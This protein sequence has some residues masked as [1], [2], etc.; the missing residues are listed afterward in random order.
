MRTFFN[1]LYHRFAWT[2]DFV[3]NTV[4]IGMWNNWIYSVLPEVK[5]PMVLELGH[6][7]GH[8]LVSIIKKN[9]IAF[10]IDQSKE[11]GILAVQRLRS[12]GFGSI[13]VNGV[14]QHLPFK[15]CTFEQVVTTFPTEFIHELQ[16]LEEVERILK[17]GGTL[18]VLPVAWITGD[19]ILQ[20]L[21]ALIFN[22]TGQSPQ[23]DDRLL[24]PFHRAGFYTRVKHMTLKT[25][26]LV[27]II[28]KKDIHNN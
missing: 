12:E 25:S 15:T 22:I 11:M 5:G 24:Y 7:P 27:F 28:A 6:G 16:T 21:A 9:I 8:L 26:R 2:Y 1:L 18:L 4:S 13:L 14:T 3:A 10:G 17:P 20:R 19:N 23:W